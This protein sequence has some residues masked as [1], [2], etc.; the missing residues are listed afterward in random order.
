MLRKMVHNRFIS[1]GQ[2]L[3]KGSQSFCREYKL[4]LRRADYLIASIENLSGQIHGSVNVTPL[5]RH[6]QKRCDVV[7]FPRIFSRRVPF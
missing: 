4:I 3:E 5:S 7:G 1:A 6:L 2:S